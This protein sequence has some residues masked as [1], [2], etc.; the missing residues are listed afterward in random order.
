MTAPIRVA[1]KT[2][3]LKVA[4]LKAAKALKVAG[5]VK[6]V[7]SLKKNP[8]IVPVP[9]PVKVPFPTFGKTPPVDVGAADAIVAGAATGGVLSSAFNPVQGLI[10]GAQN[11]IKTA[12]SYIHIFDCDV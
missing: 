12:G 1:A 11:F 10:S 8:L 5:I 3:A 9:V 7:D 4:S 2:V 6:V